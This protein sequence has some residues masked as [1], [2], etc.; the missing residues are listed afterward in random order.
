MARGTKSGSSEPEV[1]E[2]PEADRLG[3]FPHP[4]MTQRLVGHADAAAEIG[5]GVA[6][7]TS[8][9]AWLLVGPRGVGKATL[10][11]KA[12]RFAM[13]EPADRVS[14]A[15]LT[16]RGGGILD[17]QLRALSH[18]GLLL[19][20]RPYDQKDK[21][22]RTVI[23]VDEVRRLR[24]FLGH[25]AGDGAWRVVIIDAVDEMSGAAANALLKTLEEPP[26]RTVFFLVC[27][28][29]G[30]LL[31]TVRSRCRLL[32]L[33]PLSDPE[34]ARAAAAAATA[35]GVT[36][37]A[38]DEMPA[39]MRAS[40]G[41]PGRLLAL[42]TEG[43]A[44]LIAAI[45]NI[46]RR[47]PTLDWSAIHVLADEVGASGADGRFQMFV[48]LLNDRIAAE[49]QAFARGGE[50]SLISGAPALVT[51]TALWETVLSDHQ[52]VEALNLDKK[53]FV[54]SVVDRLAAAARA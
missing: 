15:D 35:A 9:H 49:I 1:V 28:E 37:P 30:K 46:F 43:G 50:T 3:T 36:L 11:Y 4:R 17:A 54:L 2:L 7:G 52:R 31:P 26:P 40:E 34:L 44:T 16:I 32:T 22:F 18:P 33:E 45:A 29:P 27:S 23:T 42:S 41:R 14:S 53:S 39:L 48:E 24:D 6:Q 19:I 51:W 5:A 25:T 13:S 21:R 12:A 38:G 8:H 20:R 10:A 47:L